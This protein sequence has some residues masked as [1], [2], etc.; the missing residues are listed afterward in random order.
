MKEWMQKIAAL[1]LLRL[2]MDLILPDND[3]K[4][5]ADLGV[6]LLTMLCMLH[7]LQQILPALP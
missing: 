3:T 5:Y 4:R 7:A 1:S 6:G 2:M